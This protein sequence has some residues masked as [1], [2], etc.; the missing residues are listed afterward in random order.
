MASCS[1][2]KAG[3]IYVCEDCGLEIQVVKS[4]ADSEEGACSCSQPLTC[5]GGELV[6]KA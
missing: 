2:M 6:L 4:C 5:C 1:E 3:E